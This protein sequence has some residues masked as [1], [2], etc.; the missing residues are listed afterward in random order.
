MKNCIFILFILYCSKLTAYADTIVQK[1]ALI[2]ATNTIFISKTQIID[3]YLSP[4]T[5]NGINIKY[6]NNREH[7]FSPYYTNL[8]W[9]SKTTVNASYTLNPTNTAS[10]LHAGAN[11]AWGI[12]YH[13]RPV[14]NLQIL[15]GGFQDINAGVKAIVRNVNNFLSADFSS[16][17][18]LSASI[19][20]TIPTRKRNLLLRADFQTPVIGVMFVPEE[21]ASYYEIF[22]LGIMENTIHFSSFHNKYGISQTYTIDV[23]F[24]RSTWRFGFNYQLTKYTAN[25]LVFKY[26]NIGLIVGW[27][28]QLYSFSGRKNIPPANFVSTRY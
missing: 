7:L 1:Q 24:K 12:H 18:Y 11:Y 28:H 5:Y 8:S 23:P 9:Q 22:D 13:F 25:N 26:E 16:T 19:R 21:G 6:E 20:Y 2:N 15:V 27:V 3:S 17:L 4:L 10:M 14:K